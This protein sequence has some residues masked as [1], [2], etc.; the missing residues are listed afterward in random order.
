MFNLSVKQVHNLLRSTYCH[1]QGPAIAWNSCIGN[2]LIGAGRERLLGPAGRKQLEDVSW[3]GQRA[4]LLLYQAIW[5]LTSVLGASSSSLQPTS[6]TAPTGT[7]GCSGS[8][9]SS[10][11]EQKLC[12]LPRYPRSSVTCSSW[13]C[14]PKTEKLPTSSLRLFPAPSA[15]LCAKDSWAHRW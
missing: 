11:Q 1:W 5:A 12:F 15:H 2:Q 3:M 13:E 4:F 8:V 9:C 14:P 7:A 6:F 10:H